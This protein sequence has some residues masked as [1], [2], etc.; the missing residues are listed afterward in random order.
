MIIS[1][2]AVARAFQG[3]VIGLRFCI[4]TLPFRVILR[5]HTRVFISCTPMTRLV[6]FEFTLIMCSV[7]EHAH[8][9]VC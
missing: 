9:H 7:L 3:A 6:L 8:V 5:L 2:L 4:T 1:H